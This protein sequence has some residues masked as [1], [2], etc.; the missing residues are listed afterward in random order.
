MER[1]IGYILSPIHHLIFFFFLGIFHPIQWLSLKLGGYQ[2]HKKSVDI[3]NFC[4]LIAYYALGCRIIF[5]M[6]EKLPKDRPIIF[7]ANHQSMYDIPPLIWFLREHHAKFISKIE[8]TKNIPSIS[9]N[10]RHGGG[11]NIDRKDTKQSIMEILKLGDRMKKNNWS[12]VIFP[13]GTRSRNGKMKE[14]QVGGIAT[15]LKKAPN[16]LIVPIAIENSWKIVRNGLVFIEACH[17]FKVTVLPSIEP[18]LK[19]IEESVKE[20]EIAIR[21]VVERES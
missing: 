14:F 18:S 21:A 8:L 15:I 4:L 13:E 20:A 6:T 1:I 19:P 3:L 12:A 17:P 10:L 7:V 16:A 11:A 9:F 5:K 2:A